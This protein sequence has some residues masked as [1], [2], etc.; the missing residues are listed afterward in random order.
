VIS[1]AMR[2]REKEY[3]VQTRYDEITI[4]VNQKILKEKVAKLLIVYINIM[5]TDKNDT[6]FSYEDVTNMVF[7]IKQREKNDLTDKLKLK[8]DD[9]RAVDTLFK[10]YK[11]GD[12]NKGMQKALTEY[13]A[14]DYDNTLEE[15]EKY[16]RYEKEL[17]HREKHGTNYNVNDDV[18]EYIEDQQMEEDIDNENRDMAHMNEDYMDGDYYGDE[19]GETMD[20]YD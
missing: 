1:P 12:W 6:E 3:E 15:T 11:L 5:I 17:I 8:T 10:K 4:D 13:V 7:K 2:K 16:Q 14:E 9:E 18:D 20:E 19:V